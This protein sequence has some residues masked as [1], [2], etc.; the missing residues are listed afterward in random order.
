MP[1][2]EYGLVVPFL[3]VT[4]RGGPYDDS[5]YCAGYEMGRLDATLSLNPR[6]YEALIRAENI[7]Q[8]DLIAMQHG[9]RTRVGTLDG[10][11]WPEWVWLMCLPTR[12]GS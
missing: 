8:A 10:D 2:R 1:D 12:G 3:P 6:L 5:A 11:G 9:Y 4:S 7:P